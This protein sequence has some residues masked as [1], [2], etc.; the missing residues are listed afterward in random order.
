MFRHG[1]TL[2]LGASVA[3]A[4][5]AHAHVPVRTR[6]ELGERTVARPEL[7]RAAAFGFDP[8]V[9]DWHWLQAVQIVGGANTGDPSLHGETLSRLIDVVTTLDPWV[10]HPYRFGALWLTDTPDRIRK[11]NEILARGIAYH[12]K[13]W[14]NRFY[15]AFNHFFFLEDEEK[16]AEILEGAIG[17]PNAPRY[18]G[19]LAARLRSRSGGLEA[20]ALFLEELARNTPDGFARAE[21]EKALDEIETERRA[22]FLDGARD[23]Y[24]KRNGRDIAAVEDLTRGPGAVLRQLPPEPNGWEWSLDPTS[25]VIVSSFYGARYRPH[26]NPAHLQIREVW[27]EGQGRPR[28]EGRSGDDAAREPRDGAAQEGE[29]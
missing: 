1:R 9:A 16:A 7:A 8:V 28:I 21:Y 3:L 26:V 20:S 18:L 4:A 10:D 29:G 22:R 23:E 6:A 2:L 27:R 19:R 24:R 14:R 12:P 5:V 25:G 11:A 13:D 17:L 15:L